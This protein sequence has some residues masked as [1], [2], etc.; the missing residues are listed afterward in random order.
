MLN[1]CCWRQRIL[2]KM[3]WSET[4]FTGNDPFPNGDW[5]RLAPL[6]PADQHFGGGG[7][8]EEA[9]PT[10]PI[11]VAFRKFVRRRI[12]WAMRE[13]AI[14]YKLW[15]GRSPAAATSSW[16][17]FLP[18]AEAVR[19]PHSAFYSSPRQSRKLYVTFSVSASPEGNDEWTLP[20]SSSSPSSYS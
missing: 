13:K 19:C 9:P 12:L 10:V 11:K 3:V 5:V 8:E 2:L 6:R 20:R 1:V 7:E 14:I 4:G 18:R 16:A 17:H 15:L